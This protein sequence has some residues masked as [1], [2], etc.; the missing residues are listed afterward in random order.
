M[1]NAEQSRRVESGD[2]VE[3][4]K[5]PCVNFKASDSGYQVQGEGCKGVTRP[6]PEA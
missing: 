5:Q 2:V 4:S 3:V 6:K 1:R